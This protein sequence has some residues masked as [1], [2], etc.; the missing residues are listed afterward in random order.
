[1]IES[2]RN[3]WQWVCFHKNITHE[4]NEITEGIKII[5]K[6]HVFIEFTSEFDWVF[7]DLTGGDVTFEP[8]ATGNPMAN[9]NNNVT[10]FG[11]VNHTN[12]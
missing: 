10:T 1:M 8:M 7:G 2:D 12:S 5:F 3:Q 9:N 11:N 4:S 6:Y